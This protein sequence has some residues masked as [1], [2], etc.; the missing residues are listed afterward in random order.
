MLLL[1][2][3]FHLRSFPPLHSFAPCAHTC[4]GCAR[5]TSGKLFT[6]LPNCALHRH[7][8]VPGE[9][10]KRLPG[11]EA[12][13]QVSPPASPLTLEV[14]LFPL[15]PDMEAGGIR[16][17]HSASPLILDVPSP[18]Y[19]LAALPPQ[20]SSQHHEHPLPPRLGTLPNLPTRPAPIGPALPCSGLPLLQFCPSPTPRSRGPARLPVAATWT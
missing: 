4:F 8:I 18:T 20:R 10:K 12:G 5:I 7:A 17:S 9:T 11:M 1:L 14:A 6:R 13:T 2:L 19:L 3:C 16:V 15:L